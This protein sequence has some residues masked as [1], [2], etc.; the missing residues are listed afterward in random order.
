[1]SSFKPIGTVMSRP[2]RILSRPA[3]FAGAASEV[4]DVANGAMPPLY[5]TAA[6]REALG[7]IQRPDRESGELRWVSGMW[8][9]PI[10]GQ[11]V[12][13]PEREPNDL[14]GSLYRIALQGLEADYRRRRAEAKADDEKP[15]RRKLRGFGD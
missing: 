12:Y 11:W 6:E 15:I 2:D 5:L 14:D 10:N 3:D 8:R 1:M 4:V 7:Y 9:D 13:P